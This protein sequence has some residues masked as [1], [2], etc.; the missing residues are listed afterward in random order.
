MKNISIPIYIV[1]QLGLKG[2]DFFL[3]QNGFDIEKTVH[4]KCDK[5]QLNMLYTQIS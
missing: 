4:I 3:I 2:I 5:S 1:E